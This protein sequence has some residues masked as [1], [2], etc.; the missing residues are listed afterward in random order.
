VAA[1]AVLGRFSADGS[2]TKI[3]Y[4]LFD[5]D[6]RGIGY[7]GWTE[8]DGKVVSERIELTTVLEFDVPVADHVNEAEEALTAGCSD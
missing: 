6:G 5:K 1:S 8:V 3:R 7:H 4:H 2:S